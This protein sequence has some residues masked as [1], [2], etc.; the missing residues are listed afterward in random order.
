M[1]RKVL[2]LDGGSEEGFHWKTKISIGEKTK[3][4]GMFFDLE[5]GEDKEKS[6]IRQNDREFFKLRLSGEMYR[7]YEIDHNWRKG[8]IVRL[9]TPKEHRNCS[10]KPN[11]RNW[12]EEEDWLF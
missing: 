10:T 4:F 8:G 9:K 1:S 5:N 2:Y 12:V 11:Q 7:R 6:R 3:N